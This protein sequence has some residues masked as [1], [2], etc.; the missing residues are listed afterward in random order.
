M[1]GVRLLAFLGSLNASP[2]PFLILC[3]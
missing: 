2:P 3:S 1:L